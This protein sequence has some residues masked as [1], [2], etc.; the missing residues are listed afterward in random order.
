M[1]VATTNFNTTYAFLRKTAEATT[2]TLPITNVTPIVPTIQDESDILD[3][4]TDELN[5]QPV[6]NLRVNVLKEFKAIETQIE[7]NQQQGENK[8][9]ETKRQGFSWTQSKQTPVVNKNEDESDSSPIK[10]VDSI[11][12]TQ[13]TTSTTSSSTSSYIPPHLR[14]QQQQQQ[15]E[16][17][18]V[19]STS[20]STGGAYV[21]P[22]LR[23]T[24]QSTASSTTTTNLNRRWK[25]NEPNINDV[26]EFPSL[27]DIQQQQ[28]HQSVGL[29]KSSNE[30]KER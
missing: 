30:N 21:P 20:S 23:G 22:H 1:G 15:Q 25:K 14:K 24:Q 27:G 2:T 6:T 11:P 29:T 12:T 26:S 7:S 5:R 16:T 13:A 8:D 3:D 28:Q 9:S 17:P 19:A 4:E 18:S 10:E